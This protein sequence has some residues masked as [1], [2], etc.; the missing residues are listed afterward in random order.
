MLL[1]QSTARNLHVF[2]T[3]SSDHVTGK[4]GLTL[5][6]KA[7][8]DGAAFATI[9]P[10]VTELES[11]WYSLALTTTH[12]NTLGDF[13]LHVTS[14]GADPT[15]LVRQV[16]SL[17]P[18]DAVTLSG[19]FTSTM[20]TSIGTAVAASAVASVTG[21]VGGNVVG[22][23]ASVT[24]RVTA[25]TDQL[26]GQTVTAAAGVTFPTSVA[27][28]TNITAAS[29][30]ALTS[31]YDPAKTAAQAG[32]AMALTSGERTTLAG[33]V[34]ASVIEGTTTALQMMRGFAA[35]LLGKASGLATSTA[36]FRDT[37][38]SKDRISAT[39]DADG[40]RSA[41]TLDLT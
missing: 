32:D 22:S 39:V 19:D 12:T 34:W 27:S 3:D 24:A 1:K 36:K 9:T 33:V 15:D 35:A 16:V 11:G 38:D 13:S 23:V 6:I 25:N 10:T 41:V 20:K 17:L 2:M 14:S 5:T 7:S 40:N 4:T 28:P 30:V 37:G 21:N 18:G 29:G 26:A 31:A 8:K